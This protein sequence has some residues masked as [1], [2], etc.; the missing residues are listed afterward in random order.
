MRRI[1]ILGAALL[2][3]M[4]VGALAANSAWAKT[5]NL[6]LYT[7]SNALVEGQPVE[8]TGILEFYSTVGG[9]TRICV[10]RRKA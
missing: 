6:D 3:L 1:R 5:K 4:A 7:E 2:A 9:A 10:H 8:V